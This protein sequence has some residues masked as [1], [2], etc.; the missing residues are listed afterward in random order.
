M[1]GAEV[2]SILFLTHFTIFSIAALAYIVVVAPMQE[3]I[4]DVKEKIRRNNFKQL[5]FQGLPMEPPKNNLPSIDDLPI[6]AFDVGE[7]GEDRSTAQEVEEQMSELE[8]AAKEADQEWKDI[9]ALRHG[10]TS[11]LIY[12]G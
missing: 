11:P 5:K 10:K 12:T 6:T 7:Y 2:I 4:E 1:N 9:E 8:I 3:D